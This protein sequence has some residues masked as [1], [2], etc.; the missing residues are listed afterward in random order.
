MSVPS[1]QTTRGDV[2]VFR[3]PQEVAEAAAAHFVDVAR[4]AIAD[5]G[6][7]HVALSGGS[8][9]ANLYRALIASH[10]PA[11]EWPNVRFYW[12][13]ERAVPPDHEESNFRMANE[14]LLKPLAIPKDQ[15]QRYHTELED[16]DACASGYERQV[17]ESFGVAASD[18]PRFDLVLLGMGDDGHTASLFPFTDALAEQQRLAVAN[19]VPQLETDRVTLTVRCLNAARDVLF[20]VAGAAKATRLAQVLQGPFDGQRLPSQL[21]QPTDGDLRWFVDEPAASEL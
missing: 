13:D 19:Q 10:R 12:G 4:H 17:R 6:V 21:I 16:W 18:V 8:T 2:H 14:L 3:G 1:I 15:V 7:F 20:L 5:R 11:V 9:P